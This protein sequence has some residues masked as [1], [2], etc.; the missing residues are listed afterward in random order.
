[1]KNSD[2]DVAFLK[3]ELESYKAM[4]QMLPDILY[5]IDPTG[6]FTFISDGIRV[7]GYSPDEL[8]GKHYSII[9]HPDDITHISRD[10]VLPNFKGTVTGDESAPKLFDE[11]RTS[12][13]ATKNL[14]FRLLPK[15]SQQTVSTLGA[16]TV[17]CEVVASGMY[18]ESIT[19]EDKQFLSTA[20]SIRSLKPEPAPPLSAGGIPLRKS[21][22]PIPQEA[23]S[24][25][26]GVIRNITEKHL[27]EIQKKT[28]EDQLCQAQKMEAIGQLAGGIAHDF[29][30]QLTGILGNAELLAE[31]AE[32]ASGTRRYVE[33]ILLCVKRAADLT[34]QLLAFARKGKKLTTAVNIHKSILET[35]NMLKHSIT[36]DIQIISRL[37]APNSTVIGDPSQLQNAILNIAINA[38]DSMLFGGVIT[39]TTTNIT[40]G[41]EKKQP[42]SQRL[43]PG[44]Y[45]KMCIK[46]TGSGILPEVKKRIFEPFFTTKPDGLGTGLGLAAVYG[47]VQN[48]QGALDVETKVDRGTEFIVYMPV[49]NQPA[50]DMSYDNLQMKKAREDATILLVDD[51]ASVR[52][53]ARENL[54]SLGYRVITAKEGKT[55]LSIYKSH[56]RD[57]DLVILDLIMPGLGGADTFEAMQDVNPQVKALITS[58]FNFNLSI[59]KMMNQG[60]LGF[61][62]K[63]YRIADISAKIDEILN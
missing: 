46:D 24:G 23:Y 47:I 34:N 20:G 52:E 7:L 45:I 61:I 8:I 1:M 18:N 10:H 16:S 12:E 39:F 41:K 42:Q 15:G 60:A 26:V 62:H 11:R 3:K 48:H 40:M 2:Q 30:N 27:L 49:T 19:E 44:T 36:K 59:Q 63:P 56:Y 9:I 13:R 55:A 53:I 35:I 37:K 14:T 54:K 51:E 25:T 50:N 38:R 28:L 29:N 4:L 57:I 5:R 32:S 58:G 43:S 33:N 22:I 21:D 17:Y 31:T 6:N